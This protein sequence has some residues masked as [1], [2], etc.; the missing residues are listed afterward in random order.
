[1]DAGLDLTLIGSATL[2][3]LA[4]IPHCAAMCAAPCAAVCGR[5]Q[6]SRWVFQAAR[7]VGY[8]AAGAVAA[9]SVAALAWWAQVS[10]AL[11]PLWLLMQVAVLALGLTLLWRGR[12]PAWLG[13]LGHTTAPL[14]PSGW[15]HV[16]A[17]VRAAATGGMWV[18]W[19]CGL[20]QSALVVASLTQDAASGAA[21]MAA[22][23]LSSSAGLWAAPWLWQRAQPA[24]TRPVRWAGALLVAAAGFVLARGLWPALRAY[25]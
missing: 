2:L 19:P 11:R 18:A 15:A 9:G 4:G 20:L 6:G 7:L 12:Q 3:G 17:P 10:P 22:F 24:G 16:K 13:A 25:C 8:A 23:A 21:A 14:A 5:G 1:M